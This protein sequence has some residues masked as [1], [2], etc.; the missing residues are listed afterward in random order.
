MARPAHLAG[1]AP[2]T[3]LQ[4]FVQPNILTIYRSPRDAIPAALAICHDAIYHPPT[5]VDYLHAIQQVAAVLEHTGPG[6]DSNG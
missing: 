6:G 3:R 5:D 1:A 4:Q 2:M